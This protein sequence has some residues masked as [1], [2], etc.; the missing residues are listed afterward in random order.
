MVGQDPVLSVCGHRADAGGRQGRIVSHVLLPP[1]FTAPRL[2]SMR[3]PYNKINARNGC[4][5]DDVFSRH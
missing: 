1:G 3:P 2:A 4:F 5:L